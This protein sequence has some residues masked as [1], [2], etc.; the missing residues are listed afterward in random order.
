[1]ELY[2]DPDRDQGL[3]ANVAA[4]LKRLSV[5]EGYEIQILDVIAEVHCDLLTGEPA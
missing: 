5:G 2:F 1:M 4:E 3:D